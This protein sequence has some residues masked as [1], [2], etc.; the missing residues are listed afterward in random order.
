MEWITLPAD[1][2]HLNSKCDLRFVSAMGISIAQYWRRL[3]EVFG[4]D[5]VNVVTSLLCRQKQIA[6]HNTVCCDNEAVSTKDS[7]DLK[8]FLRQSDQWYD[9]KLYTPTN[10]VWYYSTIQNGWTAVLPPSDWASASRIDIESTYKTRLND[11]RHSVT[12]IYVYTLI[13]YWFIYIIQ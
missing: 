8:T 11:I 13:S 3:S 7:I 5:A 9:T 2:F 1:L 12:S 10:V 6:M 4:A